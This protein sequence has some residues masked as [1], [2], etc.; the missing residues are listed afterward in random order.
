M[1]PAY[2][3]KLDQGHLVTLL[4]SACCSD[5]EVTRRWCL[6]TPGYSLWAPLPLSRL[7]P[8]LHSFF[9][10]LLAKCFFMLFDHTLVLG[11]IQH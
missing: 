8:S 10:M 5:S 4:T 2:L 1:Y 7:S 9:L 3:V 11:W 6:G